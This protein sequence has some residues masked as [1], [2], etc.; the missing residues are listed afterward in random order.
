M[1]KTS[2]VAIP[3]VLFSLLVI[4]LFKGLFSD[5]R[6]LDSQV[7]DKTLPAFSLPD[8][9]QPDVTYTPEDLKGQVTILNVW[10]VW[11]VTCAVEMPYLTQLKNEQDVHIVGLYF[12]QDLDPDF[13]TKTLSR[14]QQEVTEMLSRYGNPYAYNI[15][16]VYRDTSLDLGVTGAPEHFVI[17]A[18]GVIRMH[19]IG[20]IN[21]RVW[22]TKVGPLYNKLVA[23]AA[24]AQGADAHI[25]VN[26]VMSDDKSAQ[27]G[28]Q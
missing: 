20:D 10:G 5:P 25:E 6:E 3:L 4:F 23:Q 24:K 1:K 22:N 26:A 2:L 8:L 9:M 21:E 11:C 13:G 18:N 12:D 15:F 16:D 27:G 7:K 28:L 19:H 17:D 14:V